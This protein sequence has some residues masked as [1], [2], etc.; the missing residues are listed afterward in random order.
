[1]CVCT[2]A[3]MCVSVMLACLS[4]TTPCVSF[5]FTLPCVCILAN[6]YPYKHP[7]PHHPATHTAAA[8]SDSDRIAGLVVLD[9]APVSY[10]VTDGTNWQDT[11][12]VSCVC[13][14]VFF[15]FVSGG[16][17]GC[18]LIRSKH[19]LIY[20]PSIVLPAL[21]S[22]HNKST[23]DRDALVLAPARVQGG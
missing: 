16:R 22:Y 6:Q 2:C 10:S 18:R 14:C 20:N 8:L 11:H 23:G 9:I 3:C 19:A 5:L 21:T 15:V 13:V 7:H 4:L 17:R 12:R 1:M